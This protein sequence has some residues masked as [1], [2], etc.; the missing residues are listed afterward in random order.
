MLA[1]HQTIVVVFGCICDGKVV[2]YF[3]AFFRFGAEIRTDKIDKA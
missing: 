1:V 2:R 3:V